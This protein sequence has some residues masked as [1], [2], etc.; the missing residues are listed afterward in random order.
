MVDLLFLV[1]VWDVIWEEVQVIYKCLVG[2][3]VFVD[4]V[5]FYFSVYVE[6]GGDMGYLY[7]GMLFEVIQG[8]I[9]KYEFGWV[10][11]LLDML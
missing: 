11:L 5:W 3:V 2:G 7:S 6:V 10:N 8:L 4:V 1:M 9:D